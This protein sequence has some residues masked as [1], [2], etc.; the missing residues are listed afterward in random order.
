MIRLVNQFDPPQRRASVATA[1]CCSCCCCCCCLISAVGLTTFTAANLSATAKKRD[2]SATGQA[3]GAGFA[4]CI[5]LPVIGA[6]L[7]LGSL[8]TDSGGG[9]AV[10][11][12]LVLFAI[13]GAILAGLYWSAHE[14]RAPLAGFLVA[15]VG[16]AI[17][18][19]EAFMVLYGLLSPAGGGILVIYLLLL[20]GGIWLAAYLGPKVDWDALWHW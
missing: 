5:F 8:T 6:S 11:I 20:L 12:S 15:G 17:A 18:I 3:I 1:T 7:A 13:L 9:S 2:Q 16:S 19:G 4:L 14:R 10:L